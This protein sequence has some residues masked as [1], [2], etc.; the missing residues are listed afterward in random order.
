MYYIVQTL[1]CF[2]K[3]FLE[4]VIQAKK[5]TKLKL[6]PLNQQHIEEILNND[7]N[8]KKAS[9]TANKRQSMY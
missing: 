6:S 9:A 1:Y 2:I 7:A 3:L 8:A 5:S 4:E